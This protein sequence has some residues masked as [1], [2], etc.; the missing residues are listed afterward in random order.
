M[1]TEKNATVY[2]N[3]IIFFRVYPAFQYQA[4]EKLNF[5]EDILTS[6]LTQ[7]KN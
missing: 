6:L 4:L 1:P 5:A 2:F 3:Q 7:T